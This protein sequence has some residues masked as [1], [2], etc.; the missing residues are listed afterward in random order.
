MRVPLFALCDYHDNNNDIHYTYS[1]YLLYY[2]AFGGATEF[3]TITTLSPNS[4][5]WL[6]EIEIGCIY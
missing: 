3:L 1:A 5:I 2:F 4:N 6:I